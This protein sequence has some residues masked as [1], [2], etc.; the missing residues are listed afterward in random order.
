MID[1][2]D[3]KIDLPEIASSTKYDQYKFATIQRTL[4]YDFYQTQPPLEIEVV[5]NDKFKSILI[6]ITRRTHDYRIQSGLQD[7]MFNYA[8]KDN[9]K[10]NNQQQY[11]FDSASANNLDT[12]APY[13]S[14]GSSYTSQS[15][16]RPRQ[17]FFGGG[18]LQEGDP[19][20]SG[21]IDTTDNLPSYNGLNHY[22]NFFLKSSEPTYPFLV[23][24]EVSLFIE[25]YPVGQGTQYPFVYDF[26]S[27]EV[28]PKSNSFEGYLN[29]FIST[30]Y[31]SNTST[32]FIYDFT[33]ARSLSDTILIDGLGF[34]SPSRYQY[35]RNALNAVASNEGLYSYSYPQGSYPFVTLETFNIGGGND[36]YANSKNLYTF[37]NIKKNINEDSPFIKYYK[38]TDA[39]KVDATDYKL[40]FIAADQIIK[41]GVLQYHV[42]EDR[43][44]EYANTPVIGYNSALN[45]NQNEIVFRHRGYYEP[46]SMDIISYWVREDESV[47]KHFE[48]DFLLANTRISSL[49][50]FSG[51]IR[52]YGINK[53]AAEEI[54]KISE[55]S[56]YRSV[57]EFIHEIAVD[58]KNVQVL[59]SSW[60]AGYFRSYT[61]L[62]IYENVDG[63]VETKEFKSFLGSKAM[64]VPKILDVQTFLDSE[65]L[66]AVSSPS[67]SIGLDAQVNSSRPILTID[68]S[69]EERL[70]R[71]L[72]EGMTIESTEEAGTAFDEFIWLN[73]TLA[74]NLTESEIDTLKDSY[75]RKNLINLY[76]VS[77]V[78]L[79]SVQ[80]DGV[81]IFISN[82]T[83]AEK[84]NGGYRLDKDCQ[85]TTVSKFN[86]KISKTLDTTKSFGYTVS[87]T[88]KR[89]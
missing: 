67:Q 44:P 58:R 76:Y 40:R 55:G 14:T 64:N 62:N 30:G 80:R 53:V 68:L 16:Y 59:N 43:P 13:G 47:S 7:Y 74:L 77:D 23:T 12:F 11:K 25:K 70:V 31:A 33:D 15:T 1:I 3:T 28:L 51:L 65:A 19:K 50:S 20:L 21:I 34:S 69:L 37:A 82:L 88:F 75:I 52:N 4:P 5:K 83:E 49:P 81:P 18:Y 71:F 35:F 46:K 60:D 41:T 8:A 17:L 87:V 29:K 2:D 45:T 56:A 42:D 48:K 86:Y 24:D 32:Y 6:V 73:D 89:I 54:L 36:F 38:V 72:K 78:I 27:M 61:D 85:V 22:I 66:F 57:Y 84:T 26:N 10:N 79:Y 9:L 63:Y 39:G